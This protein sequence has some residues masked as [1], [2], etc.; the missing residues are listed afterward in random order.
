MKS[1]GNGAAETCVKNLCKIIRG[2]I[3]GD[4]CRGTD[5]A[6]IGKN[7]VSEEIKE[8]IKWLVREYEPRADINNIT[9]E[10]G[11]APGDYIVEINA[12]KRG[13]Q[14]AGT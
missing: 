10:S 2:E 5:G 14:N 7:T 6:L 8:D 12:V 11:E 13:E 9:V 1:H 3:Y 4:R